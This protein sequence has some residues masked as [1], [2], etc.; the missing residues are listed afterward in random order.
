MGH[1]IIGRNKA[2]EEIAYARFS[3][4]NPNASILYGLLDASEYN[5]GVSGS[6]GGARV[7]TSLLQ[8]ALTEFD[9]LYGR[10]LSDLSDDDYA[11]WDLRQIQ[12][13]LQNCL[14]TAREEEEEVLVIFC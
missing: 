11:T 7:T 9:H 2:G 12:N 1:D 8:N 6:G 5:A 3:M 10:I 4:S 14:V 13:F